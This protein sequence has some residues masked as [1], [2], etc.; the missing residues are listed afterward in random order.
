MK[1]DCIRRQDAIET[2]KAEFL[3]TDVQRQ[4]ETQTLADQS[5]AR[6]WNACNRQWMGELSQLPSA[7]PEPITVNIDHELTQDEYEKLRKDMANAPIMLLPSVQPEQRKGEWL[8]AGVWHGNQMWTCSECEIDEVVPTAT[9]FST[10]IAYPQWS[11][12]PNCGAD[13][14]NNGDD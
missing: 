4:T 7:Q 12:C 3:N 9:N 1:D 6:G 5:F 14:R 2:C 10:G 13:M 11:F 8:K